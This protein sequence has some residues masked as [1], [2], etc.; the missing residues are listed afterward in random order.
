MLK[1][2]TKKNIIVNNSKVCKSII[3]KAIGLMFSKKIID[4][5]L[6]FIFDKEMR[7]DL[8]MFF[9]FYPI[10]VLF[11]DNN[12]KVIEIKENFKPFTLYSPKNKSKY[13][14]EIPKNTVRLKQIKVNDILEF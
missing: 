12:K 9:V 10:D 7:V 1:N 4:D 13:V 5:C 6:I 14:I 3:S 8:H 11:L 2:I